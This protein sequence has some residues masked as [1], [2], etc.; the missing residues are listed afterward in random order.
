MKYRVL[1]QITNP[2]DLLVSGKS[3]A[4]IY[5][6]IMKFSVD[7]LIEH[8]N[9]DADFT[10]DYKHHYTNLD[11]VDCLSNDKGWSGWKLD[12]MCSKADGRYE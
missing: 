10:P 4:D 6:K 2:V 5:R 1:G 7:E 3:V 12:K 8:H 9:P 11:E